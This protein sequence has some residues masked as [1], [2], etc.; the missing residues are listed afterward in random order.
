M[1]TLPVS[2]FKAKCVAELKEVQQKGGELEITLNGQP[3]ARVVAAQSGRRQLGA[4]VGGMKIRGNLI[5][6]NL[7]DDFEDAEVRLASGSPRT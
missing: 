4:Q 5:K 2:E 3:L 1:K 7:D 6:S